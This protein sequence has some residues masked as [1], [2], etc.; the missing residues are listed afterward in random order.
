M[1]EAVFGTGQNNHLDILGQQ[2]S[3]RMYTQIC[4]CFPTFNDSSN[5]AIVS[6]LTNGLERLSASFRWLAGQVVNEGSS[7]GN[8]G[9]FKIHPLDTSPRLVVKDLRQDPSAPTMDNLRQSNFAISMLDES[10]IAPRKAHP[11]DQTAS[12]LTPVFI[13]QANF[14]T[15]GLLLVFVSQHQTMDMVGQGQIM[16]LFERACYNEP[17]LV[18][19]VLSG[20]LPRHNLIPFLDDSYKTG[21]GLSRQTNPPQPNLENTSGQPAPS[22]QPKCT[23]AY[24]T[25][26]PASLSA[27]KSLATKTATLSSGQI[28]TDDALSAFIWQSIGR[29]RHVR[30]NPTSESTFARAVDVRHFLDIPPTYPGLMHSTTYHTYTL[31]KLVEETLG[32]VAS[33]LRSALDPKTSN[34][35]YHTRA[36]ATSLS[37][38]P[39]KNA[40][41]FSEKLDLSTDIIFSSWAKVDCYKLDFNLGLGKPEAVRRPRFSTV[42]SLMFLMPKT[43]D[44]EIAAAICL[45]HEDMKRL[46]EDEEFTK[47]GLYIG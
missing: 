19:D 43:L 26:T 16:H 13:L 47:Y 23:W 42:E 4:L 24:F 10:L 25:F 2:P 21:S 32:G 34:L 37:R 31:Q 11:G 36:L 46:R 45:R 1:T 7:E 12:D 20:N 15:G 38:T 28:S 35:G 5:S 39:D 30:L 6:T 44:G 33:Q 14:I 41:S 9:T 18:E 22:Q 40:A 8:T 29:A 3:F 17:F 27:L